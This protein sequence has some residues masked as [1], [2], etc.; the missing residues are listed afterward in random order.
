[1]SG[2]TMLEQRDSSKKELEAGAKTEIVTAG[3][4]KSLC[5]GRLQ[6]FNINENSR[7]TSLRRVLYVHSVK[8]GKKYAL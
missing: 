3:N 6:S 7:Q 8:A 2:K 4:M 5:L 1:M